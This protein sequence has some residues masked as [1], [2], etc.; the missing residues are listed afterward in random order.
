[1]AIVHLDSQYLTT[2]NE[3]KRNASK[4]STR[5]CKKT[6]EVTP[7]FLANELAKGKS[8]VA[9]VMRSEKRLKENLYFQ[10][11]IALDFDDG[12]P[13]NDLV[14]NEFIQEHA[15]FIYMTLSHA[16]EFNKSRV[17][18]FLDKKLTSNEQVERVYNKLF[19]IFPNV[20]KGCKDSSRIFF[21]GKDFIEINFNNTFYIEDFIKDI[22]IQE[23]KGERVEQDTLELAVDNVANVDLNSMP[24]WKLIRQGH[25]D[26]VNHRLRK[27]SVSLKNKA[28]TIEYVKS[29]NMREILGIQEAGNFHDLFKPDNNPSASIFKMKDSEVYLYKRHSH[30]KDYLFT[31]SI[32]EVVA[33]LK[34]THFMGALL[35]L[36]QMM[37][38]NY[39]I[40][41]ELKEISDNIDAYCQMLLSPDLEMS[42]PNT[43]KI[44]K[45]GRSNYSSD[46]IQI[47]QILKH[48]L[49]ESNGETRLISQLSVRELSVRI[50]GSESKKE[51]INKVLN[52]MCVTQFIEKLD[53]DKIPEELLE[54]IMT[55]KNEKKRKYRKNLYEARNLE[56]NFFNNLEGKCGMLREKH[57]TAKATLTKEGLAKT[58]GE[59]EANKVFVQDKERKVSKLTNEVEDVA[60]DFIM[61]KIKEKGYVEEKAVVKYLSDWIG[62]T[63][64]DFKFKQLRANLITGYGLERCRLN[65]ALKKE[66][67]VSEKYT[68]TQSP[69]ILKIA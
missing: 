43:H 49:V 52:L 16:E 50:Y 57:F 40:S 18:F 3:A 61:A 1:M 63:F 19:E 64:S 54:K 39:N 24:T 5:I 69:A 7:E 44:F 2:K 34:R 4:I 56:S 11:V 15:S 67:G 58:L 28:S 23:P 65:K 48:C 30:N 66:F 22:N 21:G 51:R 13:I 10:E 68:Q 42:Y 31:G 53:D 25:D 6:E 29:I 55:F 9:G 20:D 14:N 8:M 62:K 60:I 36:S 26:L 35:Y 59:E 45:D 37:E 41:E 38:I 12:T 33:K 17:V 27:Y 46:V 47:L 32:I